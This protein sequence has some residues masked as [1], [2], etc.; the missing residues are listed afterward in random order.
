MCKCVS[1]ITYQKNMMYNILFI[2]IKKPDNHINGRISLCLMKKY[3]IYY[4]KNILEIY[5]IK[6]QLDFFL[7]LKL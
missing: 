6:S 1:L 2:Y 3:Q 4:F 7:G 5:T